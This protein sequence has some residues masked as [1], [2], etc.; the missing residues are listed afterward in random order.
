MHRLYHKTCASKL[1]EFSYF[2]TSK[3]EAEKRKDMWKKSGLNARCVKKANGKWCTVNTIATRMK[4]IVLH[5]FLKIINGAKIG[6][7]TL[8]SK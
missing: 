1:D 5:C 7:F 8:L 4:Y 2:V 6:H 3:A